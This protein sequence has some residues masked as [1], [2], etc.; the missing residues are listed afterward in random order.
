MKH[1]IAIKD[2]YDECGDGCCTDYGHEWYVDGE[3]VHRG[4]CNDSGWLAVLRKLGIDAEL[5]GLDE[6]NEEVWEL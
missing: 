1:K 5:V 2:Y 3:Q 4:P 6:T